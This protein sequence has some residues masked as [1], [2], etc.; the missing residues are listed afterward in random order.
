MEGRLAS[1]L[2]S[3]HMQYGD[4]GRV[5]VTVN[6]HEGEGAVFVARQETWKRLLK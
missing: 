2:W 1:Y 4:G 3:Q 5:E 6:V